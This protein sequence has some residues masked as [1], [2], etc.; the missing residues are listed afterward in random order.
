MPRFAIIL[1]L[2][3]AVGLP[4]IAAQ[5]TPKA[6]RV[7]RPDALKLERTGTSS[8]KFFR[9]HNL[10]LAPD[11]RHLVVT[12][13]GNDVIKVLDPSTLQTIARFGDGELA[14]PHDAD[15]DPSGR[16]L[17]ADTGNDRIAIYRFN[18]VIEGKAMVE[19]AGEITDG[20]DWPEG[21]AAAA[22]GRIYVTNV[23]SNSLVMIEGD[24][25]IKRVDGR[26]SGGK[27]FDRPHDVEF[28]ESS[29]RVIAADSGN[30]RLMIYDRDLNFITQLCGAPY[31]FYEPKYLA[32]TPEGVIWLADEYNSQIKILDHTYRPI[33]FIGTGEKGLGK[34]Q[35]NW[36]EGV[37]VKGPDVWISDTYNNRI[38]KYRLR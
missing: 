15:F 18:G 8:T 35:L 12:D 36:P 27:V 32:T 1:C 34:G 24:K 11:G 28:D 16:L 30:N 38:L 14:G 37:F 26:N 5:S 3:T 13:M 20:I 2:V 25:I 19:P 21:V 31:H 10:V 22:D 4:A 33:G 29:G 7:D 9:P 23:G 6:H 17:I